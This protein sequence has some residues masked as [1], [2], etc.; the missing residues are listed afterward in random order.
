M[1]QKILLCSDLDR[2]LLPNG[3]QAESPQARLRLQRLAQRPGIILAY[4]SGRHKALIQSAIREYDLPLPDFAIGDVG[5]TIYQITDNQWHPWEDW[6][7]EISQDWQGINQ[8]GLAK[9]FADITPLRLQE[10]EKQNRYKLSYYAPPELDWENLI[11]Q[12]AQRLQAQGIQASFIWSVDETAQIGLLDI[13]PKRAN[14]LHA[15]R[16]LMERQHFDKSHTVFAGD[17]GNDLEVLASG[18]QAIL[19]RNAQEEVRQEA[20]RRL[21]PEHSQQLYLARGGFM[22]L[23]GYYSAGVLE[24]L[25]HFFPETRAWMETGREESAEEETAQSCAIYRSCKKND[26]YLYV[27]SQDDFSRVPG[28]LLEMLGKLEF[29]MRLELRPEISLAQANIRE[30]MQMLREKGYF[31]QLSSREYRRS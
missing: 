5:T 18:L 6:S 19:V 20:L 23:N 4:V 3:H 21:P 15:I 9:L 22:G 10:P 13:L 17:S 16:F 25:A 29:V 26:S 27:E 8:A 14:K 24:G 31:L 28:K 11:P 30:V 7:K 1:K 2:T 12:L